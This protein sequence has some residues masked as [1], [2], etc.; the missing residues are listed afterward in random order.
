[1]GLAFLALVILVIPALD[2]GWNEAKLAG[3]PGGPCPLYANPVVD[4]RPTAI[5]GGQTSEPGEVVDPPLRLPLFDASIF[6]PPER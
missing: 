4:V 2:F 6:V 5:D 1:V 3:H